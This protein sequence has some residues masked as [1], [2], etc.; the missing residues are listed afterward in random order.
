M[1]RMMF[2]AIAAA[3]TVALAAPVAAAKPGWSDAAKPGDQT[4]VEIAV[5][6][7]NFDT[8]VA[9]L[10]CTGLVDALNG[11]GQFTVF[12]PTDNAFASLGLNPDNVCTIPSDALSDI[13]LYHVTQGRRISRSVLAANSYQ[14]LNGDKLTKAELAEAGVSPADIS[15]S[16]GVIHVLTE[17]V[18]LPS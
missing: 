14:M 2:A 6:S 3:L 8:L 12:A 4:I 9:A 18:L 16:N 15:A 7:E 11:K 1:R 10:S 13:L 17:G 5:G